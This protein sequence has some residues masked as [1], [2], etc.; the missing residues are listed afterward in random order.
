MQFQVFRRSMRGKHIFAATAVV[1]SMALTP[2][3]ASANF[4]PYLTSYYD[5]SEYGGI[6]H[7][8]YVDVQGNPED[9]HYTYDNNNWETGLLFSG[10][11]Y[12]APMAS[13][14]DSHAQIGR[15]FGVADGAP[16]KPVVFELSSTPGNP[17]PGNLSYLGGKPSGEQATCS[18][19]GYGTNN[20]CIEEPGFVTAVFDSLDQT[21]HVFYSGT[22]SLPH[23]I[24]VYNGGWVDSAIPDAPAPWVGPA[25][26]TTLASVWDGSLI[27]F[28]YS[29]YAAAQ[30]IE[31]Y[32]TNGTWY[33]VDWP[34][35]VPD[36]C[37]NTGPSGL[38]AASWD[39]SVLT[40]W[41]PSSCIDGHM[42][43]MYI[44]SGP[45]RGLTNYPPP[46]VFQPDATL[47]YDADG[48]A[49]A[50]YVGSDNQIYQ[51]NA[52]GTQ[53]PIIPETIGNSLCDTQPPPEFVIDN[54]SPITGLWDGRLR[55]V[56]FITT[57]G[58]IIELY[59][60][61]TGAWSA[62]DLTCYL[63]EGAGSISTT[64]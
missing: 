19:P 15:V 11:G 60:T 36:G 9:L 59:A 24:Y 42:Q 58:H 1:V 53:T 64:W 22:D 45:T 33:W 17:E 13:L 18:F 56:Y 43:S 27:H 55:Q 34:S 5:P 10:L 57:L 29:D 26:F 31:A 30:L 51:L 20:P 25:Y 46:P 3:D 2:K 37:S 32:F 47:A 48:Q 14:Y 39:S 4:E 40:V 41:G 16:G 63:G 35:L 62:S 38:L 52:N 12:F 8:I 61:L 23:H 21:P 50:F 28:F 6:I 44:A 49:Q 7:V 54:R